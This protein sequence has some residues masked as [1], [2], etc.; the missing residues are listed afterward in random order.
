MTRDGL[1]DRVA[2]SFGAPP[3]A[4]PVDTARLGRP[5]SSSGP[6]LPSPEDAR[7]A[8]LATADAEGNPHLVPICFAIDGTRSTPPSTRSRSGLGD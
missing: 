6:T 8:R 4:E 1:A 3:L 7:V 5:E 2:A